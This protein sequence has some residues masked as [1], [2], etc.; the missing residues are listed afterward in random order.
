MYFSDDNFPK[1]SA[2]IVTVTYAF[3][4]IKAQLI[5]REYKNIVSLKELIKT[6]TERK[7]YK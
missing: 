6:V 1:T 4:E 2:I 7:T 5:A 3:S